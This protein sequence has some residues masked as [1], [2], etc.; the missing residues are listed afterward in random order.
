MNSYHIKDFP[1]N[2]PWPKGGWS[3]YN[4]T[5]DQIAR[6]IEFGPDGKAIR[7]DSWCGFIGCFETL[8]EV[9][10]AIEDHRAGKLAA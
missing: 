9:M 10:R 1:P 4:I 7:R 3:L 6:R 2:K 8:D 5:G